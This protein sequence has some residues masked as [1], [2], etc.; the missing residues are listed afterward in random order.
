MVVVVVEEIE[1]A[2]EAPVSG[3]ESSAYVAVV[4]AAVHQ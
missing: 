3:P 1:V 4:V 2:T